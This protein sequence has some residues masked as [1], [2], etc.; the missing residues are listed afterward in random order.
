MS[1]CSR[2]SFFGVIA[3]HGWCATMLLSLL[4]YPTCCG[5][6]WQVPKHHTVITYF[7]PSQCDEGNNNNNKKI[8]KVKV[9][10]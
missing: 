3:V 8:I 6:T 1:R 5:L 2:S 7:P 10:G 9:V 4:K